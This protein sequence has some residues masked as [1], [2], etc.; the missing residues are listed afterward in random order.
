MKIVD[1]N[2]ITTLLLG[3]EYTPQGLLTAREAFA[4]FFNNKVSGF[5]KSFCMF[6][7]NTEWYDGSPE[8]HDDH[9]HIRSVTRA[10]PIPTILQTDRR[11]IQN[12]KRRRMS[13]REMCRIADF[14]CQICHQKYPYSNL[15]R[16]HIL[17]KCKGGTNMFTNLTL[18]CFD[19][20][21]TK[22]DQYPYTD[23]KGQVLKPLIQSFQHRI[24]VTKY[25]RP[26]WLPFAIK[27]RV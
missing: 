2:E 4:V 13:L 8:L 1:T 5:D 26:E 16:E 18:T 25:D 6:K 11:T 7:S 19:C 20:N 3:A 9:P 12:S 17:P 24:D 23:I 14:T 27:Q 10:W 22:D 21:S 15:T